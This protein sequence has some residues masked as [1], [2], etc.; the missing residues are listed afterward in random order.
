MNKIEKPWGYE[1]HWAV[2][3]QYVGK[4]L[5]VKA[6]EALSLQYHEQK[7]ETMYFE[8]GECRVESGPS[9]E[10]LTEKIYRSGEVFHIPPRHLHRISAITDCRIFEVST[11]F[12]NDVVRLKDQYGRK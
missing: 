7:E 8:S 11:N 12:L 2:T 6:G 9:I 5:F 10:E 4:I 1:I 3:P